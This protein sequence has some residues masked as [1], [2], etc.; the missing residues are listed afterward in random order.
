MPLRE[1]KRPAHRP[2]IWGTF[3]YSDS[4]SMSSSFDPFSLTIFFPLAADSLAVEGAM[5]SFMDL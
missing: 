5:F 3:G 1:A 4:M 2:G